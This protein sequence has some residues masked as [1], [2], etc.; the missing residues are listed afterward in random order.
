MNLNL[1]CPSCQSPFQALKEQVDLHQG[2]VRCGHC[3]TVFNA[4]NVKLDGP[5]SSSGPAENLR[6]IATKSHWA[7]RLQL[8]C[9]LFLLL[10]A[11]AQTVYFLRSEISWRYPNSQPYL[12]LACEKLG[13]QIAL[14]KQIDLLVLDDTDL[15]EDDLHLGL[16][17]LTSSI[18]NQAAFHQAY[19]NIE[20]TL[21][22]VEDQAKFQRIFTPKEYL[23]DATALTVG[24]A[25][26]HTEQLKFSMANP[27]NSIAGYR[28]RLSY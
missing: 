24:L 2:V 22:D 15:I 25:A 12:A 19:P 4:L 16:I 8:F 11:L 18:I 27:D 7:L 26:G 9:L 21:T 17:H 28:V 14:A 6:A 5:D 20:L 3:F 23:I 13:C 10:S 1:A